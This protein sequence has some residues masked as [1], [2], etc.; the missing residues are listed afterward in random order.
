MHNQYEEG[1]VRSVHLKKRLLPS[2][3]MES[4]P[5]EDS[6]TE[7]SPKSNQDKRLSILEH[8]TGDKRSSDQELQLSGGVDPKSNRDKRLSI[9]EHR[10]RDKRSSDQELQLSGGVDPKSNQDK[11]LSI[12]EHRIR[13][14]RSS[15]QELRLSRGVNRRSSQRR[16][17]SAP[18][19]YTS[20][21]VK[22]ILKKNKSEVRSNKFKYFQR[23][24]RR[25]K[26][27]SR[28]VTFSRSAE[29]AIQ[30]QLS[31]G[32]RNR[33]PRRIKKNPAMPAPPKPT[34]DTEPRPL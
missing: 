10:I 18:E 17:S 13:D 1:L 3:S 5:S 9:L 4:V 27:S 24:F 12:L 19:R 6:E 32:Y 22:S 14:K 16:S 23:V 30:R 20:H 25:K 2:S 8:R 29:F 31:D 11:R 21:A 15:D 26:A 28:R 34:P 7:D 33:K